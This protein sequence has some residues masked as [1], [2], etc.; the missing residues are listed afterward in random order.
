MEA[1][2]LTLRGPLR[3]LCVED[4][5]LIAFHLEHMIEDLGDIYAGS[6]DSFTDLQTYPLDFAGALIDVDLSDGPTGPA[7]AQWL[8]ARGI[9]SVFV[10]GQTEVANQHA[11]LAVAIVAKPVTDEALA[12]AISE[13][14]RAAHGLLV[15]ADPRAARSAIVAQ[16]TA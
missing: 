6:V 1:D 3:I 2:Q 8:A 11:N 10:T 5:P 13:L 9:P 7:A 4:N 14:R 12:G 16:S 15:E